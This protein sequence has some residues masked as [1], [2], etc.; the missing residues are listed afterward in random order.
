MDW[1]ATVKGIQLAVRASASAGLALWIAQL[2]HLREPIYAAIAA[3]IVSDLSPKESR[4]LG[5]RR[6]IATFIG[7][8]CGANL[9]Q[10]LPPGPLSVAFAVLVAMLAC[11]FPGARDGARVAGFLSGLIVFAHDQS[12]EYAWVRLTETLLGVCVA[13]AIS[14]VPK[15]LKLPEPADPPETPK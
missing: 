13:W 12:W 6:I 4:K 5:L 11:Q 9:A 2:L 1:P 15:Y 10:I 3:I 14:Y 8:T 7:A